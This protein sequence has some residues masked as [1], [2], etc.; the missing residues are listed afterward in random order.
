MRR[1]LLLALFSFGVCARTLD[2]YLIDVEGGKA[3]LTVAPSGESLLVDLGFPGFNGRDSDRIV[4]AAHAAGVKRIDYLLITH[5]DSDHMGDVPLLISKIPIRHILDNGPLRTSGKG[6]EQRYKSYVEARHK[7][8]HTEVHVG[9]ALPVRGISIRVIT[10]GGK[11]IPSSGVAN[12]FCATSE[13]RPAIPEDKED[14]MSIGLLYTLGK[15]RM[16]DLADFEWDAERGLMCPNNPVGTVS[17]YVTSVHAQSKAGSPALVHAIHPR[18][19]L[20]DNGPKKGGAPESWPILR[21]SPGLEDI[22]QVHYSVLGGKDKNPPDD[23]NA[24]L[25]TPCEA[26]WLKLSANRDGSFTVTNSRNGFSKT[27]AQTRVP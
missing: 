15:F 1:A 13:V 2:V 6:V 21:G 18:V 22:W 3:M 23:F 8:P 25:E 19:I 20:M 27:Y 14:N 5:Y 10:A 4:A 16:V 12:P 9:G 26:R 17:V 7:I 11:H 24:N